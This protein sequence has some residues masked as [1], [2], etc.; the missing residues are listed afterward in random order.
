MGG[1]GISSIQQTCAAAWT[2]S[3]LSTLP[4]MKDKA[5]SLG[6]IKLF[7]YKQTI[8]KFIPDFS[9]ASFTQ[10]APPS[11]KVLVAQI[12]KSNH[13][14]LSQCV[15]G[16]VLAG[17]VKGQTIGG[18]AWLNCVYYAGRIGPEYFSEFDFKINL[19][20]RLLISCVPESCPRDLSC[21]CRG[22]NR[23][24]K[25]TE[26]AHAFHF[27]SCKQI[28]AANILRHDRIVRLLRESIFQSCAGV[29]DLDVQ[30]HWN[31]HSSVVRT[32]DLV[33]NIDG[34]KYFVDVTVRVNGAPTYA[35]LDPDAL[36]H[37]AELH[38]KHVYKN[39]TFDGTYFTFA[40]DVFGNLSNHAKEFLK[41]LAPHS[42]SDNFI[43]L[44]NRSLSVLLGQSHSHSFSC[45]EGQFKNGRR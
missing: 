18:S 24:A 43:S 5:G 3:F 36:F 45:F 12:H 32:P 16:S 20:L 35:S 39:I 41:L 33:V 9:F 13:E 6:D 22:L 27:L 1:L 7:M 38:K 44:F 28:N 25:L 37:Q 23:R 15:Q 29:E 34:T 8:S 26:P 17:W 30:S 21:Y 2:A 31:A 11:Q 19:R 10:I 14:E 4:L 40:V 42:S